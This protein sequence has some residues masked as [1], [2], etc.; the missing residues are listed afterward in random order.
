VSRHRRKRH[1]I[2]VIMIGL[3]VLLGLDA[4]AW[5]LWVAW[6]LLPVLL[7]LAVLVFAC[8]H[9]RLRS[10]AMAWIRQ[11]AAPAARSRVVQGQVVAD[12]PDRAELA[13]LRDDNAK[14]RTKVRMLPEFINGPEIRP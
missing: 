12:S 6:Q 1:P 4:I 7:P 13:R 11:A 9:W 2:T 5:P 14:L 10:R 3:A 8:K